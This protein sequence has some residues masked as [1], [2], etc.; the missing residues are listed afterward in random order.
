LR[1]AGNF[2]LL[3]GNDAGNLAADVAGPLAYND[4]NDLAVAAVNGTTGITTHNNDVLLRVGSGLSVNQPVS[5]GANVNFN[6][7]TVTAIHQ[8]I[9]GT[10][11][12]GVQTGTD[13]TID[14]GG[15]VTV[16]SNIVLGAGGSTTISQLVRTFTG[17]PANAI[18][19]NN[20]ANLTVTK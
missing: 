17:G 12:L 20:G 14:Q 3:G 19:L 6:A 10:A 7:G 9:F 15:I 1:G 16:G 18:L 4:V 2:S 8:A 5:A 11:N 13:L